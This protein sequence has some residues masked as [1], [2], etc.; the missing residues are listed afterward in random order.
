M[1]GWLRFFL[2]VVFVT[3][4]GGVLGHAF[5]HRLEHAETLAALRFFFAVPST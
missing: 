5:L 4:D 1:A 2:L 3:V